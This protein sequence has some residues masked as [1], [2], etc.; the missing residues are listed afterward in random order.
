MRDLGPDWEACAPKDV[1]SVTGVSYTRVCEAIAHGELEVLE[2][3]PKRLVV[4]RSAI[5]AWLDGMP[6]RGAA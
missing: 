1:P 3:S 6:R 4:T 5:R 2:P